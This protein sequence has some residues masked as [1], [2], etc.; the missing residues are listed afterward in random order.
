MG[1]ADSLDGE[2]RTAK[3]E[4]MTTI[5]ELDIG[6][7]FRMDD[8]CDTYMFIGNHWAEPR[9]VNLMTGSSFTMDP[10]TKIKMVEKPVELLFK[11]EESA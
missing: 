10:K 1:T 5:R 9:I 2:T 7:W 11:V 8:A 6:N 3:G 4:R